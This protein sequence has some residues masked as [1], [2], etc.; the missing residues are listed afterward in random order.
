MPQL[1]INQGPQ[2]ALLFDNTRSYFT[3]VGYVRTS[4]FQMEY[5]DV[6]PQ[7]TASFGS[8]VQFVIPKAADLLGPV[9]L[10]VDI[11][12]PKDPV[13]KTGS[14]EQDTHDAFELGEKLTGLPANT[15]HV[16]EHF[17]QWVDEVGF[18][19]IEKATFSIGSNDIETLTGEQ[20]QIRNELMTSDEQRLGHEH[21][22]KTGRGALNGVFQEASVGERAATANGISLL[23][24]V[25]VPSNASPNPG[26]FAINQ[27]K[28]N[29]KPYELPGTTTA[30]ANDNLDD[31]NLTLTSSVVAKDYTRMIAHQATEIT[32]AA[33]HRNQI[34][35]AEGR[36]LIIPLGFFFT[37]HVSQYFPLA[38]IAGCNDIR[39]QIKFRPLEQLVQCVALAQGQ[40]T[41]KR[42]NL[43]GQN[44]PLDAMRMRCHYV[45]VTGPEAQ[46]L[47]AK[48]HVRLLKL[49]QH[50]PV[51]TTIGTAGTIDI[52]LTFLHPV[53]TLIVTI[54]KEEDVQMT[55][56]H[57]GFFFYHGD[58]T[59]P[60]YDQVYNAGAKLQNKA[61]GN[62]FLAALN[63]AK[64]QGKANTCKLESIQLTLNGQERHPGL[65]KGLE[66]NY[67]Q[68]RLL[69]M[70]HS[71][72][73][74]TERRMKAMQ[75]AR[76]SNTSFGDQLQVEQSD[77][78]MKN[79]FVYP[80]A[81]N[82]EGTN[83]SGSVNFSKVSHAKL[84]LHFA[85][86]YAD[87]G[88][89]R[90]DVYALYYN[91]LQI[92]DGRALLSFA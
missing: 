3:N 52:P 68:E 26:S 69:P 66:V 36:K 48:E 4:N 44:G 63:R 72:S 80:F 71:N 67:L 17:A 39:I 13:R 12:P 51:T 41:P 54:R 20:M 60:N 25:R 46:A 77:R 74:S 84:R 19:M 70:L 23:N 85:D 33:S 28:V 92:K 24:G 6:E 57:G 58:G 75:D 64:V 55:V 21:V 14:D 45:H 47:M 56:P 87:M 11:N 90:V 9:D 49:Y 79:I 31:P 18:A 1:S 27:G 91:W 32:S 40:T 43:F 37:R 53:S 42:V 62:D 8:T 10:L 35:V 22:L 38:S 5:R 61:L 50:Q 29:R 7:N 88:N 82:P 65:S 2:D 83:P 86:G 89:V 15:G 73:S 34:R 76:A 78:G 30:V 59:N 16:V 81:L